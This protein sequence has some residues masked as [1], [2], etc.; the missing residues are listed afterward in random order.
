MFHKSALEHQDQ[1]IKENPNWVIESIDDSLYKQTYFIPTEN[2]TKESIY[3]EVQNHIYKE[4]K[5]NRKK[6]L[7]DF[8]NNLI[9]IEND[10]IKEND[11]LISY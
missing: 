2:K 4:T 3:K 9:E 10:I 8:P 7:E 5:V 6:V 11:D 1:T